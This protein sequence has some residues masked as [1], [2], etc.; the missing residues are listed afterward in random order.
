LCYIAVII[1]IFFFF[2]LR[3]VLDTVGNGCFP[4]GFLAMQDATRSV[5]QAEY[6]KY[7]DMKELFESQ[8]GSVGQTVVPPVQNMSAPVQGNNANQQLVV[9]IVSEIQLLVG[10]VALDGR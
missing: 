6:Q 2:V 8:G 10:V 5:T 3:H 9:V 1:I 4:G 7:L